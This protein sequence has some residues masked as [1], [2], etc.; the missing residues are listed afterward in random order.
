ML[1]LLPGFCI[2][3]PFEH[4]FS[5][6]VKFPAFQKTETKETDGSIVSYYNDSKDGSK[7]KFLVAQFWS[8][9]SYS[10]LF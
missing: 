4:Q 9:D 8:L 6:V 5:F 7:T 3:R 2:S 1:F 10:F